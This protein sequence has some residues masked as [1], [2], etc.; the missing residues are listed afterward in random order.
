[1]LP[2]ITITV[3]GFGCRATG[4]N[5]GLPMGGEGLGFRAF[6]ATVAERMTL[7]AVEKRPSAA[8]PSP[9]VVEAYT[10][11]ER[12]KTVPYGG[13]RVPPQTGFRET[14]LASGHF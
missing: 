3:I 7:E 5:D 8:F 4:S 6:G 13:F 9:F 2:I 1:M 11:R 14:Q 12:F 10:C